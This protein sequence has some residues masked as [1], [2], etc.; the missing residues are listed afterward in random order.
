ML[1][2]GAGSWNDVLS[3]I[4]TWCWCPRRCTYIIWSSH[5]IKRSQH[6]P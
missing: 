4:I 6:V 1:S 3:R 2:S 5:N